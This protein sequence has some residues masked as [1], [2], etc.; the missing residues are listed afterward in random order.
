MNTRKY[1]DSSFS[2]YLFTATV[3]NTESNQPDTHRKEMAATIHRLPLE[4]LRLIREFLFITNFLGYSQND[5]DLC[6]F[7]HI[8][9]CF[10]S[11]ALLPSVPS[12]YFK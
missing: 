5:G 9:I 11:L 8:F 1:E 10:L 12:E 2:V 6:R 3:P 4:L 7:I